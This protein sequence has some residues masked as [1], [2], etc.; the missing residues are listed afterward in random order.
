MTPTTAAVIAV[1]GAVNLISLCVDSIIGAPA[2]IKTNENIID[3]IKPIEINIDDLIFD[4]VKNEENINEN[5]SK[6]KDEINNLSA[7]RLLDKPALRHSRTSISRTESS[8]FLS[9]WTGC[10]WVDLFNACNA[11]TAMEGR[12]EHA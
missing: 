4:E 1:R 3:N 10:N 7:I 6:E 5:I 12:S 9:A 11:F 2:K 8:G